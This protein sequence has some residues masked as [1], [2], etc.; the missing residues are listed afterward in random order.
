MRCN[1]REAT[2][3]VWHPTSTR[4]T[5]CHLW[6][7][8]QGGSGIAQGRH[9]AEREEHPEHAEAA[10]AHTPRMTATCTQRARRSACAP[11]HTQSRVRKG[12][13]LEKQNYSIMP[14]PKR[15]IPKYVRARFPGSCR[16]N[17]GVLRPWPHSVS[18]PALCGSSV[19]VKAEC[20]GAG[21]GR[22]GMRLGK[23]GP[24]VRGARRVVKGWWVGE[25]RRA[26]PAANGAYRANMAACAWACREEKAALYAL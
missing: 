26:A 8:E 2:A 13:P 5:K 23:L 7:P 4:R 16:G 6:H 9:A 22:E 10:A 20:N 17:Y 3:R 14:V 1:R 19:T 11:Q 12:A 15:K 24:Q 18:E 21:E 25:G